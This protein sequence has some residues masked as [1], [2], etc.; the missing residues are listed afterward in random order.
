MKYSVLHPLLKII[1]GSVCSSDPVVI[2]LVLHP[3]G[4]Q[5]MLG[6]KKIFPPGMFSCLAGFVEPGI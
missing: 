5:C 4:K 3:D 1:S 2:M 6:R